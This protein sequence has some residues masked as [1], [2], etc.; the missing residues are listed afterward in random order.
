LISARSEFNDALLAHLQEGIVACDADGVLQLFNDAAKRFHGLPAEPLPPER[1]AEHY[2]LYRPDGERMSREEVPLFRALSGEVVRDVEMVIAP[3]NGPRRIL[4]ANGTA[5]RGGDGRL[6]GA[7][8]AMHDVTA[9][10]AAEAERT[11]A[12]VE[13]A[14]REAA[15]VAGARLSLLAEVH[16]HVI[17]SIL[18]PDARRLVISLLVPSVADRC[19]LTIDGE[20][21]VEV[22]RCDDAAHVLEEP[23]AEPGGPALGRLLLARTATR[24]PFHPDDAWLAAGL[25]RRLA[26]AVVLGRTVRPGVAG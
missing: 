20:T 23:V 9:L 6:L 18:D 12:A 24:P 4:V 16:E 17:R 11:Q 25:A 21:E 7:V 1:W 22:G 8:V 15:E 26:T 5:I 13:R 10:K 3:R 2:D 14:A 19:H